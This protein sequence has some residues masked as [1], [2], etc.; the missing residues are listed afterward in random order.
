M[1]LLALVVPGSGDHHSGCDVIGVDTYF[2][3]HRPTSFAHHLQSS[4][5][6]LQ[7]TLKTH[8]FPTRLLLYLLIYTLSN[9]FWLSRLLFNSIL[10]P[11]SSHLDVTFTPWSCVG[12]RKSFSVRW[13]SCQSMALVCVPSWTQTNPGIE[14]TVLVARLRLWMCLREGEPNFPSPCPARLECQTC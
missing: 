13:F 8:P 10:S 7:S 5:P 3:V 12:A 6:L 9:T 1:I 14:A 11:F 4:S 2:S